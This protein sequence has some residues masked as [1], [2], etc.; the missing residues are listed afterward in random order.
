M[1][2]VTLVPYFVIKP[3]GFIF[4]ISTSSELPFGDNQMQGHF[5]GADSTNNNQ[6]K[7]LSWLPV[8]GILES[9]FPLVGGL[10]TQPCFRCGVPHS[11]GH[12]F[13]F[14]SMFCA[15]LSCFWDEG[16]LGFQVLSKTD[17]TMKSHRLQLWRQFLLRA[18]LWTHLEAVNIWNPLFYHF[19][20]R[21]CLLPRIWVLSAENGCLVTRGKAS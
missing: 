7:N 11:K 6:F 2:T 1:F 18:Y 17:L 9:F 21:C 4:P 3:K 15:K 10:L 19:W 14:D 20:I 8:R 12:T 16:Y 13:H 5:L